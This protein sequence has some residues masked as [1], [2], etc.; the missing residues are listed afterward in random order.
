M[1]AAT[2]FLLMSSLVAIGSA[3]CTPDQ[4]EG[5]ESVFGGY[6]SRKHH[7]ILPEYIWVSYDAANNRSAA[8]L[9]IYV[10][11]NPRPR[12]YKIVIRYDNDSCE[13]KLY[14]LDVHIDKCW[15]KSLK[16]PFRK[17]CI[18]PDAKFVGNYSLGLK[19]GFNVSVYDVRGRQ[20]KAFVSVEKISETECVPVGESITG[21]ARGVDYLQAIEFVNIT[22]GIK[23]ETVFDIPEQCKHSED[24]DLPEELVR[25]HYIMAL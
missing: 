7:G 2:I 20:F 25:E 15:T 5:L 12:E 11:T 19:G 24:G 6:A 22:P 16:Y 13:G 3:C 10:D 14:V 23:N 17:A 1:K 8:F 21:R 4:W 9:A 18:P